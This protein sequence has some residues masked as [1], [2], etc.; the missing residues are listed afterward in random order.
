VTGRLS[1]AWVLMSL[2]CGGLLLLLRL[3]RPIL[4]RH[5]GPSAQ[6]ACLTA[7]YLSALLPLPLLIPER[8]TVPIA[9]TAAEFTAVSPAAIAE[10]AVK[11]VLTATHREAAPWLC[12][13]WLLGAAAVL[14]AAGYRSL[15]L[16]LQLRRLSR[17]ADDT[18][19]TA[20]ETHCRIVGIRR[21]V[22][23]RIVPGVGSPFLCGAVRPLVVLP[24][25]AY[26]AQELDHVLLHELTHLRQYAPLRKLLLLLG[27][28]IHWYNPIF[29]LAR[30]EASRLCELACDEAVT[31]HMNVPERRAYT[32]LLLRTLLAVQETAAMVPLNRTK[33]DL[34]RRI[35]LIQNRKKTNKALAILLAMALLVTGTVSVH[36]AA[37]AI[38]EDIPA[39]EPAAVAVE[40]SR[41]MEEDV[42]YE[43]VTGEIQ[44]APA[45]EGMIF[46]DL[47]K[48][49]A[50]A[51]L[52]ERA[53]QNGN[54]SICSVYELNAVSVAGNAAKAITSP[55]G[56]AFTLRE[57]R[58][59]IFDLT[60]YPK[61]NL[62]VGLYEPSSGTVYDIKWIY[63]G[64]AYGSMTVPHDGQYKFY[65]YNTG[66][67][68]VSVT[69]T[70]DI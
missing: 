2:I 8:Q 70:I 59:V 56:N 22:A 23:L 5:L 9:E 25:T 12:L 58:T 40:E 32:A 4:D 10:T 33:R 57:G 29:W 3:S 62:K 30:R 55:T 13:L 42:P 61:N 14:G 17:E 39:T 66:S 44:D 26:T 24:G 49:E 19:R 67:D 18:L 6:Y 52:S 63:N 7:V 21:R 20:L 11:P 16:R 37:G 27:N 46:H 1:A 45:S 48:P 54:A 41:T 34:E 43:V 53:S 60:W 28:A 38:P 31:K 15:R 50:K 36:A 64:T 65:I 47:D 35:A 69:G 51:E 68:A